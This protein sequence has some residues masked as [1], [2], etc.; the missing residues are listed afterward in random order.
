MI[1]VTVELERA[2]DSPASPAQAFALLSAIPEAARHFPDLEALLPD[3]E[4]FT[5]RLEKV[6]VG[7]ISIQGEWTS[8]YAADPA[9]G[10]VDWT[11]V[12]G[13][14]NSEV[15]G[16]WRVRPGPGGG[17]RIE[18]R[19]RA[20]LRLPVPRLMQ[21]LVSGFVQREN[22]RL[23]ERWLEN[24]ARTLAGGDGRLR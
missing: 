13:R 24:L 16:G 15:S 3:P 22:A 11:P 10:T 9:A 21:G 1:E 20:V 2:F 7:A 14:G 5:W 12:A 8:R 23:I 4:G 19:N 6:G 17:S 18:L